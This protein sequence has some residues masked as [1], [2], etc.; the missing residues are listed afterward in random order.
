MDGGAWW[1]AVHGVAKSRTRLS[2]FPLTF[3]FSLSCTGEGNGN[4]LQCSC[5]ENPRTR[6]AW[7]AAVYGVAQ[8]RTRLKWLSSSSSSSS[9]LI[10]KTPMIVSFKIY[11][12][13]D[14]AFSW[15]WNFRFAKWSCCSVAKSCPT[16]CDPVAYSTPGFPVL[17]YLLDFAKSHVHWVND[18][19]LPS[20]P[21]LPPSPPA[22]DVSQHQGLSQWVGSSYRVANVLALQFQHQSFQWI[23]RV[24][25]L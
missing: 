23:F 14:L 24:D 4:P 3:H 12:H 5:L 16:L 11:F 20:H 2:D 17:H 8:S 15:V 19:I 6:G 21:L 10:R 9:L 25:F 7:W 13:G 18:A 22:L 1:A